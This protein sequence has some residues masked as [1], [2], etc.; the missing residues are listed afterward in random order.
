MGVEVVVV[1]TTSMTRL[2]VRK[3]KIQE[4]EGTR[5]VFCLGDTLYDDLLPSQDLGSRD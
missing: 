5:A 2:K 3:E 4:A 1:V